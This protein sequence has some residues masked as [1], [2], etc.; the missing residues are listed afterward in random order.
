LPIALTGGHRVW[1]HPFSPRLRYGER[2]SLRILPPIP[3]V[4]CQAL[5]VEGLR[6][7]VRRQLKTTALSGTMAPPR[8][9]VPARDGYWDGYAYTIDSAFPELAADVAR[10]RRSTTGWG[11]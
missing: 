8:R 5:D 3:A 11:S 9:F 4:A 6:C 7:E 1:E 2:M 10:H